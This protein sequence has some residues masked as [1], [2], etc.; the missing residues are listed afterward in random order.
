M[1][2]LTDEQTLFMNTPPFIV[3]AASVAG[4]T[5]AAAPFRSSPSC[6]ERTGDDTYVADE[7]VR[8]T[9]SRPL[10]AKSQIPEA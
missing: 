8:G 1:S 7:T 10:Q 3:P 2:V 5:V 9:A 4:S 6:H